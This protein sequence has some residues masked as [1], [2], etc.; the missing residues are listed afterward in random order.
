MAADGR[1]LLASRRAELHIHP[2]GPILVESWLRLISTIAIV[3]AAAR[4]TLIACLSTGC[5]DRE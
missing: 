4:E 5:L 1:C 3:R 2:R